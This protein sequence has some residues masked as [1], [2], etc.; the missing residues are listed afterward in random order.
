MVLQGVIAVGGD[1]SDRGLEVGQGDVTGVEI[2]L[3]TGLSLVTGVVTD[4]TG[5]PVTDGVVIV[6][7]D[8]QS[9]WTNLQNRRVTSARI[10]SADGRFSVSGLP[11]GGYLA[12]AVAA[13]E[14]GRW[15][16]PDNLETLRAIATRFTLADA[17]KRAL[18]LVRR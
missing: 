7:S 4:A 8:D 14:P 16:D 17:E 13:L 12:V 10:A 3:T 5:K 1:V 6:Y 2:R 11:A 9:H 15:A 18:T